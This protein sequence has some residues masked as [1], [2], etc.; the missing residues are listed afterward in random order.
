M[1][2][3]GA[4]G[5]ARDLEGGGGATRKPGTHGD[6]VNCDGTDAA[7]R[8]RSHSGTHWDGASLDGE[9]EEKV[10][11]AV[12]GTAG[13]PA[14]PAAAASGTARSLPAPPPRR[15]LRSSASLSSSSKVNWRRSTTTTP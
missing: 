3:H 13:T 9:L 10:I 1:E 12:E 15:P 14:P 4:A 5:G 11:A 8:I 7:D 6:G 2:D